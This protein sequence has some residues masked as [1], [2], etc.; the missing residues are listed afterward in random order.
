ME[1]WYTL[2][3]KPNAEYQVSHA[4]Q[5]R[6]IETYLPEIEVVKSRG[7]RAKKPFFPCYMFSRIDL[8]KVGISQVQ[9]TPGLRRILSFDQ[10][11]I[12]VPDDVIRLIRQKLGEIEAGGGWP[13][14]PFKPGDTVRIIDGPF[15]NMLAIFDGPTTPGQRVQ[16]LLDILGHASRVQVNVIHLEKAPAGLEAPLPKRPRRTRGRGRWIRNQ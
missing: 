11:P 5:Q 13:N 1:H 2:H 9:W 15:T 10:R 12:P 7:K 6:G 8:N 4:L 14:H 3:T 16:V